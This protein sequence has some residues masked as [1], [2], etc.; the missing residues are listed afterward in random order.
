[1][2]L[3]TLAVQDLEGAT[4]F[5]RS[6]GWEPAFRNEEVTFFQLN[7][8]V[9]SLFRRDRFAQELGVE[10]E[11]LGPGGF[12]LAYNVRA[13]AEVDEIMEHVAGSTGK[14]LVKPREAEWGG[15]SGYF[16]DPDGHRWEVAWNP[17]WPIDGDGN[18][19]I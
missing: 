18:V 12:A 10:Q 9:L 13:K 3:A 11:S 7:G 17:E 4:A 16:A 8:V 2:S 15:Y 19:R 6:L 1:M 5:Y 14:V